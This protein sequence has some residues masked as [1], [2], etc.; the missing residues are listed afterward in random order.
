MMG[1]AVSANI[2][3]EIAQ[4]RNQSP[5]GRNGYSRASRR[6]MNDPQ[7]CCVS[8]N[9]LFSLWKTT[10]KYTISSSMRMTGANIWY[11]VLLSTCQVRVEST[12]HRAA[13]R[14]VRSTA[15]AMIE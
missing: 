14:I 15:A 2:V 4:G 3:N 1:I 13:A 9:P 12:N 7:L 8:K 6:Y 11:S 5:D 10:K